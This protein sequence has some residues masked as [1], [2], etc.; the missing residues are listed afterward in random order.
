MKKIFLATI[1]VI[2]CFSM[3]SI[4]EL[5]VKA[6]QITDWPMFHFGVTTSTGPSTN[7]SA[8]NFTAENGFW[9]SPAVADGRV[10]V[11]SYDHQVYALNATSGAL[12]WNYTTA[13]LIDS[14]PAVSNGVVYIGSNDHNIY[15]L[16]SGDGTKIWN[17][18]TGKEV[19]SSPA[20]VGG[21]VYVGSND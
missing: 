9:S 16:N 3:I 10:Y 5:N 18:T 12:I 2:L 14:S 8:W 20:V 7:Q 1:I 15:A 17:F 21:I 4:L 11:G 19:Q 6:D 13:E